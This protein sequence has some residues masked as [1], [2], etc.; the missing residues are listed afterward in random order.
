MAKIVFQQWN[1]A[2]LSISQ[3]QTTYYRCVVKCT[4]SGQSAYTAVKTV[5]MNAPTNC[6]CAPS[7]SDCSNLGVG[8]VNFATINNNPVCN[9]SGYTYVSSLNPTVRKGLYYNM[10]VIPSY[11]AAD[12]D[13]WIDFN[14][15]GIF[16]AAEYQNLR[17]VVLNSDYHYVADILIPTTAP[18]GSTR[19]RVRVGNYG[20]TIPDACSS[21]IGEG[22]TVDYL[23]TIAAAPIMC[24]GSPSPGTAI[25]P[26]G[27]SLPGIGGNFLL[28]LNGYSANVSGITFQWQKSSSVNGFYTNIAGGTT[29]D[30]FTTL[31]SGITYYR[32]KVTC[33][34][35]GSV[36]YS[37]KVSV[38]GPSH[39]NL[40]ENSSSATDEKVMIISNGNEGNEI[41]EVLIYPNPT[42]GVFN[43]TISNSNFTELTIDVFDIQGKEVY[44]T[45][46]KNKSN[47]YTKQINLENIA[48][49]LYYIKLNTTNDVK[50]QKLI[51]E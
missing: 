29:P 48:K 18:L 3:T 43:L 10:D 49:G 50:T 15:N 44:N 4:N 5:T 24:S 39:H 8:Q 13:V 16:E 9:N 31:L 23:L 33:F 25:A 36:S 30:F 22:Q 19:M 32:C 11:D 46:D 6:Y 28:R 27:M 1:A 37:N 17:S 41:G 7:V 45:V 14:Q 38:F 20:S 51:I 26:N 21:F 2:T 34:G 35:S 40:L 12:V 42:A 47:D